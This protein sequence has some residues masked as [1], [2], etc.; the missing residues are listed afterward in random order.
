MSTATL[1]QAPAS[2]AVRRA[3]RGLIR[4]VLR[5]HRTALWIWLAF[6]AFTAGLLLWLTGPGADAT[7]G[8]LERYGY[9]GLLEAA[10]SPDTLLYFT[11]G[12]FNDL[13]YDPNALITL[14][15]FAVAL[16]AGGP[17]TARELESGTAQLAW[18]QSVSPARWLTAKLAVPAAFVVL[19]TGVLTL[20]YLRLWS[21][22]GNL[23]IAGIGPRSVYFSLG[24]ATVA[25]PLLGLALGTLIGLAVRRILPALAFS[26][27][28]YFL[29][30]AF[31]GNHWPFQ[32]RYQQPELHSRSHAIT[33]SGAEVDDPGCYA[34]KACLARH[35]VVRF[36]REYLP[37]P[38]YW[39]RQL[40]ETGVLL[41]LTAVAVAL[42]FA[43]LRRRGATG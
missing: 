7:A 33:S 4:T 31:R 20:L 37:S 10:Y 5:L 35:D 6:V 36:T 43:L 9:G 32:G 26:G 11:S 27:F 14:A 12:T 1:D 3:P 42:A 29:V 2:P 30:Y 13:F 23:L 28:A 25:A 16:F 19:G 38:D 34:D 39:P 18:T 17:L 24:P 21:A 15:S 8:Q 41:A 22:H 40:L